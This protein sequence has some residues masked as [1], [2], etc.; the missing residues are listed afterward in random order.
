ME[1]AALD[2][3]HRARDVPAPGQ[4][5]ADGGVRRQL[6]R[7]LVADRPDH[8]PSPHPDRPDGVPTGQRRGGGGPQCRIDGQAGQRHRRPGGG[9]LVGSPMMPLVGF[10]SLGGWATPVGFVSFGGGTV[11]GVGF[12]LPGAGVVGFVWHGGRWARCPGVVS[13]RR[14]V[15]VVGFGPLGGG[16]RVVGFVRLRSGTEHSVDVVVA[17]AVIMEGFAFAVRQDERGG[18]ADIVAAAL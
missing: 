12:V 7:R 2:A 10:V 3:R 15:T 4:G 9:D 5:G 1:V 11:A 14:L 17:Q 6:A 18:I 16:R 13:R 8:R